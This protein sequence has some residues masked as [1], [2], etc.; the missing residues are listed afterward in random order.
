MNRDY[1][2]AARTFERAAAASP[3]DYRVWKNLGDAYPACW[4]GR[5][6]SRCFK[7]ALGLLEQERSIDPTNPKVLVELGDVHA[8]LGHAADA[9]PL[10]AEARRLAPDDGDV[11]YTAATASEAIGDRD[12]ALASVTA[13]I[14]AGTTC[15]KSR[16][17]PVWPGCVW[18]RG[19]AALLKKRGVPEGGNPRN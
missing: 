11:A 18:I 9:R 2:G 5:P 19:D 17:T 3:R 8:M 12:A 14:T 1:A 6:G 13:A 7:T 10:L 15:S 4:P 16:A